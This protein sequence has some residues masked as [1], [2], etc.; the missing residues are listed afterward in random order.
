MDLYITSPTATCSASLWIL[1]R[2]QSWTSNQSSFKESTVQLAPYALTTHIQSFG[3]LRCLCHSDPHVI[4]DEDIV[5]PRIPWLGRVSDGK[6]EVAEQ[7]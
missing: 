1:K 2:K 7:L 4:L 6:V 5:T 3:G